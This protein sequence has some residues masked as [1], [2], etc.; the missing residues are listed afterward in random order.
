M[1]QALRVL[2]SSKSILRQL[3]RDPSKKEDKSQPG[4]FTESAPSDLFPLSEL[5][6]QLLKQEAELWKK[7][8][9]LHSTAR[10]D[11]R[12]HTEQESIAEPSSLRTLGLAP[13]PTP[14]LTVT[15]S[16]TPT[17][18]PPSSHHHTRQDSDEAF[19]V[20]K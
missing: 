9:G 7:N 4:E 5:L 2:N 13:T 1:E 16:H 8:E 3:S 18:T 6:E 11:G 14:S 17:P 19:C 12:G 20:V 10:G 15:P